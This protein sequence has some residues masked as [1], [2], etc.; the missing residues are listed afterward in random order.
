[1]INRVVLIKPIKGQEGYFISNQG[2]I[3]SKWVN[4]G[5]HGLMKGCTL[6]ELKG[7]RSK[8]GHITVRFGRGGRVEYIHRLVYE[9]FVS[10]IPRGKVIRHLND[11][12]HDNRLENLLIGTQKDNVRDS[13]KSGSFPRGE[14]NGQSKLT[15]EDVK[16][17]REMGDHLTQKEISEKFGVARETIGHV[18]RGNTWKCTKEEKSVV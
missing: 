1:M 6:K 13:I 11:I 10:P 2:Q 18:L 9:T 16:A 12:P 8:S 5:R 17:I 15:R 4:K 7:S 14:R 3:F